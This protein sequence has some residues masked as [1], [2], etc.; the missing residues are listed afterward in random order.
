[1]KKT[2][3][4]KA[5][6]FILMAACLA[7]GGCSE[8]KT[9]E[10]RTALFKTTNPHPAVINETASEFAFAEKVQKTVLASPEIYDSAIVT[11]KEKVLVAYKVKHLKRFKMKKIE[12]ELKK[13]LE[14]KYPDREFTVSSDYKIFLEA[15]NL[16][17]KLKNKDKDFTTKKAK[18]DFKEILKLEKEMT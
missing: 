16:N 2:K 8:K 7:L 12:K 15:V 10:A 4:L 17:E 3:L 6:P 5:V 13:K 14:K 18:K 1:M 11:D 9:G